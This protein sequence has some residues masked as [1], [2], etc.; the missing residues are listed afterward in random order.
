MSKGFNIA[1]QGHV[2]VYRYPVDLD[3]S[4]QAAQTTDWLNFGK[5][6]HVSIIVALGV[7]GA[8]VVVKLQ[9]ADDA[10]GTNP[11]DMAFN[12]Y[13]AETADSDVAGARAA[14]AS[15]GLTCSGNNGIFYII[16]VDAAE[17]PQGQPFL[18]VHIADPAAAT[19]GCVIAVFSGPRYGGPQSATVQS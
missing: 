8:A 15:T 1:E 19:I 18:G 17:L 4:Q 13:K 16:E 6:S 5:H 10:S 7:T 2:A 11:T 3:S 12:V 9:S 14:V